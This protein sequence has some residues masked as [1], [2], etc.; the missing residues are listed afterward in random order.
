MP[1]FELD[2]LKIELF[3]REKVIFGR[4]QKHDK[5]VSL[6]GLSKASFFSRVS[7][8]SSRKII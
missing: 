7:P 5:P 2:E 6:E 8:A 1:K 4:A 3:T